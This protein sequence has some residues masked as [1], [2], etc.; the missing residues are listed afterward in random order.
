[1]NT[2]ALSPLSSNPEKPGWDLTIDSNGN[3][4][5]LT[6]IAAILQDVASSV[7][8]F[9]GELWYD[10]SQGVPYFTQILGKLPPS[11]LLQSQLV[12]AAMSVPG[13]TAV[14]CTFSRFE[15]R[16]LSGTLTVTA[17]SQTGMVQFGAMPNAGGYPWYVN[18]AAIVGS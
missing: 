17:G 11:Q 2:L 5:M 7:R 10:T 16:T 15:Q 8:L 13:V 1:M 14:V 18:A 9:L 3:I 12:G 6:G 4:A